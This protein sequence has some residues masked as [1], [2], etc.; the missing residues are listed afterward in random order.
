MNFGFLEGSRAHKWSLS[1]SLS[2]TVSFS[3][4]IER[5]FNGAKPDLEENIELLRS[6]GYYVQSQDIDLYYL[7]AECHVELLL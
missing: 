5:L 3:H 2:L 4:S 7:D 6:Q 1:L